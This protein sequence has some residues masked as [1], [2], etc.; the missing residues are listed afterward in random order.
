MGD[1][2]LQSVGE[3]LS[4]NVR[5]TDTVCRQGGDEF[6]IL[7]AEIERPDDAALIAEK[8]LA[9]FSRAHAIGGQDL[10]ITLSIGISVYPDD[11]VDLDA[12][13]QSADTAMY[14]AKANGR[15]SFQFFRSD[16]N[17]RAVRRLQVESSMRRAL[18]NNE[19]VL[20]FQPKFDLVSGCISGAEALIRWQD[21]ELGL[22]PPGQFIPVA[23]ECGLIIPIGRWVLFETCRQIKAWQDAGLTVVPVAV[24]ISAMEFRHKNFLK[25]MVQILRE[26][27]LAPGFLELEL[28]ESILMHDVEASASVL[29]ELKNMGLKLAI[30]DFGT[31]Y[32][33]LSYLKRFP[34]DTLKIDQ[35]FVR[36]IA[37]DAD[38]ATIV[39]AVI[40]L[41]RSLNHRVI[42]EGVETTDQ[43]TF[44]RARHCPEAQGYLFSHPLVAEEFAH[45]LIARQVEAPH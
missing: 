27:G 33:S 23:E 34:I 36:D 18:Q 12:V 31:G 2:L 3:R 1:Q 41:G 30:D 19:F 39:S 35:S 15:N 26:T 4:A 24:N 10:H 8:L 40:S 6:V 14:H 20:H 11:G 22:I 28:T 13:L 32:S 7:L 17:T 42:A 43:L 16:M 5:T 25:G 29:A 45:L 38:D 44:L 9:A 37:T 21:P